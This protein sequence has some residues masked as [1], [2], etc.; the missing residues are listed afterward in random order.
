MEVKSGQSLPQI[1]KAVKSIWSEILNISEIKDDDDFFNLGG[2]SFQVFQVLVRIKNELGADI[3]LAYFLAVP[4][5]PEISA[6][7]LKRNNE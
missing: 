2:S 6:E 1:S 4:T 7:I 5:I 3:P